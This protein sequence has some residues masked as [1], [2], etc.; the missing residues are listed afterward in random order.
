MDSCEAPCQVYIIL[1]RIR[2]PGSVEGFNANDISGSQSSER[3]LVS[4]KKLQNREYNPASEEAGY[5]ALL[6]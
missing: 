6:L 5:N 3:K 4:R 1:R 2:R